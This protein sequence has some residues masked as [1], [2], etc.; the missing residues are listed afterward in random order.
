M[1]KNSYNLGRREYL[2]IVRVFICQKSVEVG[3]SKYF[4]TFILLN[5]Y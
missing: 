4:D 5:N 1:L 3:K 2:A